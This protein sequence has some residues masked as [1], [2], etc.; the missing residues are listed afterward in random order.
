MNS[1]TTT[2]ISRLKQGK[3]RARIRRI[4]ASLLARKN[5]NYRDEQ[6]LKLLE[7][8]GKDGKENSQILQVTP[9]EV[10]FRD[11]RP[12]QI[13]QMKVTVKNK[14]KSVHRIRVFQ[15]KS[16]LF[17]CDYELAGRIA[18]GLSIDLIVSFESKSKGEFEDV[19]KIIS[20][21]NYLYEMKVF[22]YSPM[23]KIIFEPF[24]NLGFIQVGKEKVEELW[25]K[26]EG[27]DEG[28]V[29]IA[30]GEFSYLK[31]EPSG[32][33]TIKPNSVKRV[34]LTYF[35][36]EPGVFRGSLPVSTDGKSFL[37]AIDINA[38]CVEYMQFLIDKEG[39]EMDS[40]EFGEVVYGQRSRSHGFLINN[41][42]ESL[43][44]SLSYIKG[45]H[46]SYNQENDIK[47]PHEIGQEQTQRVLSIE[48]SEGYIDSYAQLPLTFICNC[49][50][51]EDH[52]IWS[53]NYCL[54]KG[55][56]EGDSMSKEVQYTCVI[57]F[58]K[59][60]L[61][62]ADED[63]T[64]IVKLNALATCPKV[65]FSQTSINFDS[66]FLG[67]SLKQDL[68]IENQ[69]NF[70]VN[71]SFPRWSH[72]GIEPNNIKIPAQTKNNFKV[73]FSPKNLGKI[74]IQAQ[75]MINE[76]YPLTL[77]LEGVSIPDPAS[78]KNRHI[79][80]APKKFHGNRL[81]KTGQ[82]LGSLEPKNQEYRMGVSS[83]NN[84]VKVANN[85]TLSSAASL[86]RINP[87]KI[88]SKD[89][90]EYLKHNRISRL[91]KRKECFL[92]RRILEVEKRIKN[93]KRNPFSSITQNKKPK[94]KGFNKGKPGVPSLPTENSINLG[95]SNVDSGYDATANANRLSMLS[96][97]GNIHST[98]GM[99]P[100]K[101]DLPETQK[102]LFVVRPIGRYEPLEKMVSMMLNHDTLGYIKPFDE[103]PPK[104]SSMSRD[105]NQVLDGEMLKKIHAG[106][107]ILNFGK[108]FVK[109]ISMK[110]FYI[111]ND[112][113]GAILVA[114]ILD[115]P[116][117]EDSYN[118]AQVIPSG[119]I[120]CFEVAFRA[121]DLGVASKV[122]SYKINEKKTFNF[123]IKA[124]VQLVELSLSTQHLEI[125]FHD[126]TNALETSKEVTL[127]NKGN[128]DAHFEWSCLNPAF[129]FEPEVGTVSSYGELVV[130]V[131]Y[132]P[133]ETK[134]FDNTF[135]D[136]RI[137]DGRSQSLEITGRVSDTIVTVSKLINFESMA[138]DEKKEKKMVLV[139]D[140]KKASA[141]YVI[142]RAK[143]HPM[144][145]LSKFEGKI[146]AGAQESISA[147][148]SS[149]IPKSFNFNIEVLWRGG[150]RS[151]INV[152]AEVIVPI[153]TIEE[154][155]F[156][157]GV[158]T[159][160]D[161]KELEMNLANESPIPAKLKLDLRSKPTANP[162]IQ[163]L[164]IEQIKESENDPDCLEEI[165]P[166]VSA[167]RGRKAPRTF[168]G[169]LKDRKDYNLSDDESMEEPE[170]EGNEDD[171][172]NSSMMM[173]HEDQKSFYLMTL[174][175][176][177]S[178]KFKLIF[179]PEDT[180]GYS[181]KLPIYLGKSSGHNTELQKLVTCRS[182][183]PKVVLKPI[184]GLRDFG[185]IIIPPNM[186]APK[187]ERMTLWIE[188]PH[189]SN[190]LNY[191][192]GTEELLKEGVFSLSKNEG[193]IQPERLA[194]IDIIF[195]PHVPGAWDFRLP[196]YID[197]D[198]DNKKAEIRL[199]GAADQPKIM[200][201]RR[202]IILPA[203]PLNI[204]SKCTFRII[205]EGYQTVNLKSILPKDHLVEL[206]VVFPQGR[207]LSSNKNRLNVEV[208]FKSKKPIS[209]TSKI[210]FE[211]DQQTTYSIFV[212]GTAD[213][214]LFSNYFYFRSSQ[215]PA[216]IQR[217]ADDP[218]IALPYK[219]EGTA[220]S[221]EDGTSKMSEQPAPSHTQSKLSS[222]TKG[223]H[224]LGYSPIPLEELQDHCNF[225][226][227]WLSETVPNVNMAEFPSSII[228]EHGKQLL[229]AIQFLSKREVP[230]PLKISIEERKSEK[231]KKVIGLYSEIIEL[232]KGRGALLNEI[233]PEFLLG[234]SDFVY[235]L[236]HYPI[237]NAH[238]ITQRL[239]EQDFHYLSMY[240]WCVVFNQILK[241][242][243]LG[244]VNVNKY[245]QL[246]RVSEQGAGSPRHKAIPKGYLNRSNVYSP[247]EVILLMWCE[248]SLKETSKRS[249]KLV[250]FDKDLKNGL[251]LAS[252]VQIHTD[253]SANPGL[254][255]NQNAKNK[256]D[257]DT[258]MRSLRHCLADLGFHALGSYHDMSSQSSL[259][260]VLLLV[261]LFLQLPS[262]TPKEEII[263][264]CVLNEMIVKNVKINNSNSGN[265]V[266]Y[267]VTL[268]GSKDF[269]ILEDTVVV[270]A[271][272]IKYFPVKFYARVSREVSA[273][274][275]FKGLKDSVLSMMPL[276]YDLH[277][278][279]MSRISCKKI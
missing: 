72:F 183:H 279:V 100:P 111:R 242:F 94:K 258:N 133:T 89:K 178:Y 147:V 162:G 220:P 139:N 164:K 42:P 216:V 269:S 70:D 241:L 129:S 229:M 55:E 240:S 212:S 53:K 20:D 171:E 115:D 131:I 110:Y 226:C 51:E 261:S 7:S 265:R 165:E 243:Y 248:E 223:V 189:P 213:N 8:K 151:L 67:K 170:E 233:R 58:K 123:M 191:T 245:K 13:Y 22:A 34:K 1:S 198:R 117:I 3:S 175:A 105:I 40:I 206:K 148:F 141:V 66:C 120:A 234:L 260:R 251:A 54:S 74:K 119:Q 57:F 194:G 273:R 209:F 92:K 225:L 12:G 271:G 24:I 267:S 222:L 25:F 77:K 254:K 136:L 150:S 76:T 33:F 102:S 104:F 230:A 50:V 114:L 257:Y 30:Q 98:E 87:L 137:K 155:Y 37:E 18:P 149:N 275:T 19:I 193:V 48:P 96:F 91:K 205:N 29:Q 202:Q 80:E 81:L 199:V 249:Q 130:Q 28:T 218:I 143:L 101:I 207:S 224:T 38:T 68:E 211:D 182:V 11:V 63:L 160:G 59:N 79:H 246:R 161:T 43:Y 173:Q 113:K 88:S 263:F 17:R 196:L 250:H 6:A 135:V 184:N 46:S 97:Y 200:F 108:C 276:V 45:H 168:G 39:K 138:V 128:S 232:L 49:D 2:T 16:T 132:S 163:C 188:N 144:I 192:I 180:L 197:D 201:D 274:L 153:I 69:G 78:L 65:T 64:K 185:K 73:N 231:V 270:E 84:I 61:Q 244:R 10:I 9:E 35:A 204:E 134:T 172:E 156:D 103:S 238:P 169:E 125:D 142:N 75:I 252:L 235:Y 52:K 167:A 158:I 186:E 236:K 126:E 112:L 219:R 140:N 31:L 82:S 203:V 107:K 47:S 15:P 26:N 95:D 93:S 14:T 106:P 85:S 127:I 215:E 195:K 159:Y 109:S 124:D 41:S 277:S 90:F 210:D 237:D 266:V 177:T 99:E 4:D 214:S 152:Q 217:H 157:Y 27:Q 21:D 83:S 256:H 154:S 32:E 176:N 62:R 166:S 179:H 227:F 118:K 5:K 190:S 262:F 278:H 71:V 56:I 228:T 86:Q 23:A 122:I 239:K 272:Q 259:Q 181:F 174:A 268:E 145:R 146:H 255:M 208:S 36:H 116:C 60:R 264:E 121:L 187:T 44:F 247:A 253:G 221:V